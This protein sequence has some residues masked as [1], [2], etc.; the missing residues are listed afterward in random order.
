MNEYETMTNG[1]EM[2]EY[3]TMTNGN[4]MNEY[5]MITNG[6]ENDARDR[7]VAMNGCER[8][9]LRLKK[10]KYTADTSV[11]WTCIARYVKD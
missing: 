4:E 2:N 7:H 6:S 9:G 3:V 5:E 1:N 10:Y 11:W 8:N